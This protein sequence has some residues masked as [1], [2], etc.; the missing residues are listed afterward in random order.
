MNPFQ[1]TP[2]GGVG[3]EDLGG[4]PELGQMIGL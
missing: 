1:E 2:G 4:E 3:P